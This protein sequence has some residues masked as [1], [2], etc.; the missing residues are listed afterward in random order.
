MTTL[1]RIA[2][3][4]QSPLEEYIHNWKWTQWKSV[5]QLMF[6]VGRQAVDSVMTKGAVGDQPQM[7][8]IRVERL[9][10]DTQSE[11]LQSRIMPSLWGGFMPSLLGGFVK[12]GTIS[13]G[14]LEVIN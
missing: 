2:H 3:L 13:V 1:P 9:I 12:L 11:S 5:N 7:S 4:N 8:D 6:P 14:I 10:T